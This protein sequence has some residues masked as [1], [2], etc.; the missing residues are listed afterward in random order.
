MYE[1]VDHPS[2]AMVRVTA[3][4]VNGVF[5]DAAK[6]LFDLM[7]DI[8]TVKPDRDFNIHL[9]SEDKAL[10]LIDWLNRLIWIHEVE[11]VFLCRF[12]VSAQ[13]AWSVTAQAW[14]QSITPEQERRLHAKSAT[15]GQ[16][17]WKE[18]SQ[19]HEVQFVIDI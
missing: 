11:N 9:N 5:E 16:L 1:F 10:L 7:T 2:E 12:K 3:K 4:N 6:A 15:Y 17:Q 19:G 8:N 18:T 13:P 14:G